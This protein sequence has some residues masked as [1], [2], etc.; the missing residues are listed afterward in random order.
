MDEDLDDLG[1]DDGSISL[2]DGDQLDDD[3]DDGGSDD[4][5]EDESGEEEQD[6][7]E[8]EDGP[9]KSKKSKKIMSDKDFS[10]KLKN[11]DGN[12]Y[13]SSLS[14]QSFN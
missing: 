1:S 2:D 9:P 3:D 8:D 5:F 7:S 11:T 4:M 14:F 6:D 13:T 12:E 10:R